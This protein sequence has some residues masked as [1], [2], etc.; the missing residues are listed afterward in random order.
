MKITEARVS[1]QDEM[2]KPTQSVKS[3]GG[4]KKCLRLIATLTRFQLQFA[5]RGNRLDQ[6]F[7][8]FT[9]SL[10][11]LNHQLIQNK[12]PET[13]VWK[14]LENF[15]HIC[16]DRILQ[17]VTSAICSDQSYEPITDVLPLLPW[18][19]MLLQNIQIPP[20]V[21]RWMPVTVRRGMGLRSA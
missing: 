21:Q 20:P 6:C 8:Y 18:K 5:K 19:C 1:K 13:A 15:F 3:K 9:L 12:R 10:A 11:F 14:V 4:K 17:K 7:P 2:S 16:F